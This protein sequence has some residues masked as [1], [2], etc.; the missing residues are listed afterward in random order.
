MK[1]IYLLS[2]I[3]LLSFSCSKE[4]NNLEK[5]TQK[6][7]VENVVNVNA[8]LYEKYKEAFNPTNPWEF[9]GAI[10]N[11]ILDDLKVKEQLKSVASR[12]SPLIQETN[13]MDEAISYSLTRLSEKYNIL[14]VDLGKSSSIQEIKFILNDEK[15]SYSNV[16]D[17]Y[18]SAYR[19]IVKKAINDFFAIIENLSEENASYKDV[20]Q[21][22]IEFEESIIK[23][24]DLKKEEKDYILKTTSIARYS[25]LFWSSQTSSSNI[26][27][28]P[29]WKWLT[30]VSADVAGGL[31]GN[32]AGALGASAGAS[33]LVDWI[34]P[35]SIKD[36]KNSIENNINS[37]FSTLE[38]D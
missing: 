13:K 17:K 29:W 24:N 4:N 23:R 34:A 36:P 19:P 32:V 1:R 37:N 26:F 14:D 7:K 8:K 9:Y 3:S 5:Q 31:T 27:A 15:N 6:T 2:V 21:S 16:V 10:H 18:T 11:D 20:K 22:I 35:L 12:P 33:T 38:K 28:R 30:V 25:S